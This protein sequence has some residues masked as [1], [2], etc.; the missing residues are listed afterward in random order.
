VKNLFLFLAGVVALSACKKDSENTPSKADL[1]TSKNWRVSA[2]TSTSTTTITGGS[3]STNTTNVYAT[4]Q[5]CEKD[6]FYKFNTDKTLIE[7]EGASKCSS[8]ALQITT[9]KWDFNSDQTKLLITSNGSSSG[10]ADDILELSASTLRLRESDV[11]T[12]GNTTYTTVDEITFTA[13]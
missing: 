10:A 7:D 2:Q 1:L 4:T 5:A 6:N 13:F 3:T 12:S 8:S 9:L 11:Y